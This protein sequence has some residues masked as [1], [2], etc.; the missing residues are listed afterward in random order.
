[1]NKREQNLLAIGFALGCILMFIFY[2]IV[3]YS[4]SCNQGLRFTNSE[5]KKNISITS[6]KLQQCEADLHD[7]SLVYELLNISSGGENGE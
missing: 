6:E 3:N 5:L 1:V 2:Q 4:N 7:L